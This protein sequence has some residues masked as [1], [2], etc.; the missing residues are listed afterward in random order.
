MAKEKDENKEDKLEAPEPAP[1]ASPAPIPQLPPE[2]FDDEEIRK[3]IL[4]TTRNRYDVILLARRWAN[5]LKAKNERP[6]SVQDLIAKALNDVLTGKV[7]REMVK[8]LPPIV[9]PKKPKAPPTVAILENIGKEDD[10]E[11][12]SKSK[13]SSKKKKS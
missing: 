12:K 2:V 11:G 4:G 3:L 1:A 10:D 9:F 8:E 6:R 13:S 5:D 7:T